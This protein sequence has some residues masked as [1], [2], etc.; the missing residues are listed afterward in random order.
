MRPILPFLCILT[1]AA[2]LCPPAE[3]FQRGAAKPKYD[4]RLEIFCDG[5]LAPMAAQQWG[6]ALNKRDANFQGVQIRGSGSQEELD[7]VNLGGKSWTARGM[8]DRNDKVQLPGGRTFTVGQTRQMYPYLEE[9]IDAQLA[10]Q[11]VEKV[12][13]QAG[14]PVPAERL[15][16]GLNALAYEDMFAALEKPVGFQ[17]LN[18]RRTAFLSR[19]LKALGHRVELDAECRKTLAAVPAP[20]EEEDLIT[21]ELSTLSR[22]T[23][24]TYALRYVGMCLVPGVETD[25]PD[26]KLVFRVV[27]AKNNP[28]EIFPVG[29]DLQTPL[30]ESFPVMLDVFVANVN[31]AAVSDVLAAVSGRIAAPILYD[32]NNM[33]RF[34][35]ETS[36]V[37]VKFKPKR[38]S[39]NEL[40]DAILDQADLQKEVRVDEAGNVFLWVTPVK[41]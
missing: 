39:Y 16:F 9:L 3:A 33:A 12:A 4:I 8:L 35:I 32:Y 40:L 25:K 26:A 30:V 10:R 2:C 7:V 15:P 11:E 36:Q 37:T 17:T 29:H 20:D 21:E 23:A 5:K 31:G 28:P 1:V 18:M 27:P 38:V 41:K 13:A 14:M 22:G 6:E 19:V 24:L 34:G